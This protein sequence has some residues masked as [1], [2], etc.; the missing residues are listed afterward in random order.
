MRFNWLW[1]ICLACFFFLLL[2]FAAFLEL[3]HS[4]NGTTQ[5]GKESGVLQD[6]KQ[7]VKKSSKRGGRKNA[8]IVPSHFME[9]D[10]SDVK[11]ETLIFSKMMFCILCLVNWLYFSLPCLTWLTNYTNFFFFFHSMLH[12]NFSIPPFSLWLSSYDFIWNCGKLFSLV[13]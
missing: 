10:V 3:V 4:S 8:S 6:S 9:T 13:S 12:A 11:E 1:A 2:L 5:K 7:T